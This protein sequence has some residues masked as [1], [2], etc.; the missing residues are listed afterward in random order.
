MALQKL[1]PGNRVGWG[2]GKHQHLCA[3]GCEWLCSI[4]KSSNWFSIIEVFSLLAF[5]RT[6][7]KKAENV[8]KAAF[9]AFINPETYV[10]FSMARGSTLGNYL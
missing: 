4:I 1:L 6:H 5:L 10:A 3:K 2:K 9:S 7:T 8:T